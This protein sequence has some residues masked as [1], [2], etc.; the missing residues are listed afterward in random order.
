MRWRWWGSLL[1]HFLCR[2]LLN[3]SSFVIH[4]FQHNVTTEL[5]DRI[6]SITHS[7]PRRRQPS[8]LIKPHSAWVTWSKIFTTWQPKLCFTDQREQEEAGQ[9]RQ[10]VRPLRLHVNILLNSM[11]PDESGKDFFI[12]PMRLTPL[13]CYSKQSWNWDKKLRR[14]RERESYRFCLA[15]AMFDSAPRTYPWSEKRG[16][17]S[18]SLNFKTSIQTLFERKELFVQLKQCTFG[19]EVREQCLKK[20]NRIS[21][22]QQLGSVKQ[23]WIDF[24]N[25]IFM[26][27]IKGKCWIALKNGSKC[28]AN[29]FSV[30]VIN[31]CILLE[32]DIYR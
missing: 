2:P 27:A 21:W 22:R 9:H 18:P 16:K 17:N 5:G 11:K 23:F 19:L 29:S 12:F 28:I 15:L 13:W 30:E 8:D 20:I 14:E 10:N 25:F 1:S 24:K 3:A 4:L 7:R 32:N 31:N 6:H 26:L